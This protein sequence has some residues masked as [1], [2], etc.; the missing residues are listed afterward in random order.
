MVVLIR[1]GR[2]MPNKFDEDDYYDYDDDYDYDDGYD[3]YGDDAVETKPKAT[4]QACSA[5]LFSP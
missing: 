3:D 5:D 4:K 1:S 2:T